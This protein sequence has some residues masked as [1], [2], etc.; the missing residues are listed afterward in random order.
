MLIVLVIITIVI[1]VRR[2]EHGKEHDLRIY[3][4]VH[5]A[6][7]EYGAQQ[8]RNYEIPQSIAPTGKRTNTR[9]AN[10]HR[11]V[12]G[13]EDRGHQSKS[14]PETSRL[15]K[16]N[17]KGEANLKGDNDGTMEGEDEYVEVYE[18]MTG[19]DAAYQAIQEN[20]IQVHHYASLGVTAEQEVFKSEQS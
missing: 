3:D 12:I 18:D 9:K 1:V 5:D 6:V 14:N 10:A 20:Q 19:A 11:T 17:L 16:A 13:E 7:N 8:P 2:K 15:T 4:T